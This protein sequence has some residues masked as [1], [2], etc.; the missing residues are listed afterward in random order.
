M[1]AQ[2]NRT[3]LR[4]CRIYSYRPSCKGL[5]GLC[6]RILPQ[7]NCALG[8][9]IRGL[10]Y[11]FY[12]LTFTGYGEICYNDLLLEDHVTISTSCQLIATVPRRLEC[13]LGMSV[14]RKNLLFHKYHTASVTVRA[15]GKTGFG[16]GRFYSLIGHYVMTKL[17][18]NL[19]FAFATYGTISVLFTVCRTS[20]CCY[21]I[22]FAPVVA[23]GFCFICHV[24]VVTYWTGVGR[25]T[26]RSTGSICY[27]CLVVV[28]WCCYDVTCICM[29]TYR[30]SVG[31]ITV[32]GTGRICY[33]RI[34]A[35][36]CRICGFGP[37]KST[38]FFIF[39]VNITQ[40]RCNAVTCTNYLFSFTP[41]FGIVITFPYSLEGSVTAGII[42]EDIE[43]TLIIVAAVY[44]VVAFVWSSLEYISRMT[45]VFFTM[46]HCWGIPVDHIVSQYKRGLRVLPTA[47]IITGSFRQGPC[48]ELTVLIEDLP[49][50]HTALCVVLW[51]TV[52]D[53]T[54]VGIHSHNTVFG[55]PL[56]LKGR[57]R[58]KCAAPTRFM[59]F[60]HTIVPPIVI[61]TTTGPACK[62]ITRSVNI[63][64]LPDTIQ[65]EALGC[66]THVNFIPVI[67]IVINIVNLKGY[68]FCT[69]RTA[70]IESTAIRIEVMVLCVGI[71][72]N[73]KRRHHTYKHYHSQYKR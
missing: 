50:F 7:F 55:R 26:A 56:S 14:C 43:P 41:Y 39:A 37:E 24:A 61:I 32:F 49:I 6:G 48:T 5:T 11:M 23:K 9:S 33:Y 68:G 52:G 34:I 51:T 40:S 25:I 3:K 20:C 28:S 13:P 29:I 31:C 73:P 67:V 22:P 54:T 46:R 62:Y 63:K 35:M 53:S 36:S 21:C 45:L 4:Y 58:F 10:K 44:I 19:C 59:R 47:K 69:T 42:L 16:T 71:R 8:I 12:W 15:F 2:L 60:P 30:T 72:N 65:I 64:F 1:Y 70:F 66:E 57:T 18:R 38:T 27:Y 17:C